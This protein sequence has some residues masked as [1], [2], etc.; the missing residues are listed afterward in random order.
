MIAQLCE[1]GLHEVLREVVS[2]LPGGEVLLDHFLGA[3]ASHLKAGVVVLRGVVGGSQLDGIVGHEGAASVEHLQLRLA[4]VFGQEVGELGL[5][6]GLREAGLG[7]HA[8]LCEGF[9]ASWVYG[10]IGAFVRIGVVSDGH[11]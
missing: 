6:L 2:V 3:V 5:L 4:G 1:V 9:G 7:D 8:G 11:S 10:D